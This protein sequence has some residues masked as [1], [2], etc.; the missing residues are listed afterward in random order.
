MSLPREMMISHLHIL[1]LGKDLSLVKVTQLRKEVPSLKHNTSKPPSHH[2]TQARESTTYMSDV[3][4]MPCIWKWKEIYAVANAPSAYNLLS[5]HRVMQKSWLLI[6]ANLSKANTS[7]SL[8]VRV[9]SSMRIWDTCRVYNGPAKVAEF[10]IKQ[11]TSFPFTSVTCS[12][13]PSKPWFSYEHVN[14]SVSIP[15]AILKLFHFL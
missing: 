9:G 6:M 15:Q 7:L 2:P 14:D 3:F 11:I 13:W 1:N 10:L 8:S 4:R 5:I 12:I